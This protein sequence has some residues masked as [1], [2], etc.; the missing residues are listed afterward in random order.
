MAV[1]RKLVEAARRLDLSPT[2][3]LYVGD[4]VHDVAAGAAA[5]M[6]TIGAAWGPFPRADLEAARPDVIAD[7]PDEV[8]AI[9]IGRREGPRT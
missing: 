7:T 8:L 1:G 5:G 6:R 9:V 4:S 2:E 3:V